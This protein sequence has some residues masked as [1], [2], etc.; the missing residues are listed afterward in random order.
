[1]KILL[2]GP[3]GSGK[4]TQADLLAQHLKLP[5]ISTGDIF[6]KL[7]DEDSTEGKR[8]KQIL[9]SGKLVDDQTTS[10]IVRDRMS[11]EDCKDG[12]VM[13]GYPR[14]MEQLRLF[15]PQF[16]RVIYLNVPEQE[17]IKRLI[18]RGRSDDTPESIKIRL[19]LYYRQTKALLDYYK[20]QGILTEID[21]VSG[22]DSIQQRIRGVV[23]GQE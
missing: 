19:E 20:N 17:V 16:G 18:E 3:Q 21:G 8:I 2:I 15:D 14:N 6:R 5:K 9:D 12:L 23:N 4:S 7:R 22:I 10:Q 1:M 11:Q 13:D